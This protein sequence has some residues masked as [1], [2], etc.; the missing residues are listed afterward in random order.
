M[1]CSDTQEL[2]GRR[3][4]VV[5]DN[6]PN[7]LLMRRYL[8][9]AGGMVTEACNGREA[10]AAVNGSAERFDV[11]L[12]DIC[13]PVMDGYEATRQLRETW[14]ASQLPIIAVS[15]DTD[16]ETRHYYH[17]VGMNDFLAKPVLPEQLYDCLAKFIVPCSG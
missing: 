1:G 15:A 13:M 14:P 2:H 4:L 16:E 7:R 5:D 12:M 3:L 8:E 11:V 6:A 9:L 17:A 10:V